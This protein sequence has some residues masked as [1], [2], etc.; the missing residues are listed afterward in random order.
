MTDTAHT[1]AATTDRGVPLLFVWDPGT[2]KVRYYDTRYAGQF[3]FAEYGQDCGA[4]LYATSFQPDATSGIRGW[5]EVDAWDLDATTVRKVGT[6][7]LVSG[8]FRNTLCGST[9]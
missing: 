7:L 8:L 5:H 3:G 2:E 6:W 4:A 1:F 9:S